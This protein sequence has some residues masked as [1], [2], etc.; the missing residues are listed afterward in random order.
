MTLRDEQPFRTMIWFSM[1]GLANVLGGLIGYGIGHIHAAVPAWKFPFIIFGSV[2]VVW[3]CLFVWLAPSNPTTAK[4]LTQEEKTI[5]VLRVVDNETG[6]DN[7]T[8]KWNQVRESFLDPN[9]WIMNLISIA[10]C[11]PNVSEVNKSALHHTSDAVSRVPFLPL[12]RLL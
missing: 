8:F 1:N 11:I 12:G 7:K 4:W 3:G 2:T 5:A 9:F 10:N 6:I